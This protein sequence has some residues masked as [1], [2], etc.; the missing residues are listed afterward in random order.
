MKTSK[1]IFPLLILSMVILL[2]CHKR[3]LP[4]YQPDEASISYY[5]IGGGF[6]RDSTSYSF[7]N[8]YDVREKDTLWIKMILNGI[9]STKDRLVNIKAVEG[10]TAKEGVHF[11][12]P[13]FYLPANAMEVK[14]PVVLFKTPDLNDTTLKIVLQ[15]M[16]SE[17]LKAG[18]T[19]NMI[20]GTY[21]YDYTNQHKVNFTNRLIRPDYSWNYVT[22]HFG[23]YSNVKYQFM[24]RNLQ[25][26]D[27]RPTSLGGTLEYPDLL[28]LGARIGQI[29]RDY[30]AAN[31]PLIDE[32]GAVVTFPR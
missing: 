25:M 7:A 4:T 13:K 3:D 24:I 29:W 27:F 32:N 1:N 14:S 20:K 9:P 17:D 28:N 12:L 16:D 30:V 23:A 18:A 2:A 19:G 31:G 11:I 21:R 10:T 26:N 6:E 5:Y 22:Q 15:V 8:Q